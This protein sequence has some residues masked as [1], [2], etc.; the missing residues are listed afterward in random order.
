MT[1]PKSLIELENQF[2]VRPDELSIQRPGLWPSEA[3]V[4]YE[5]DGTPICRGKCMRAVFYRAMGVPEDDGK[6]GQST[7]LMMKAHLGRAAEGQTTNRWKEM[8]IWA[9]NSIKFYNRQYV[10]SGELDTILNLDGKKILVEQKSFYGFNASREICGAKRPPIPGCPKWGHFLQSCVYADEYQDKVD[11]CRLYYLE[12]GD[13]HRVEFLVGVDRATGRPYWQQIPGPYWNMYSD[14]R[15]LAPFTMDDIYARF[16]QLIKYIRLEQVPPRDF[17]H[18]WDKATIQWMYDHDE[19]S[20]SKYKDYMSGKK[21]AGNWECA[22]CSRASKCLAD[23][24]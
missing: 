13:G 9:G 14:K 20:Q 11:E 4:M 6:G 8:G 1:Q 7:N 23:G 24:E 17:K 18:T 3:S 15:V 16:K 12:R 2:V 21:Q 22:Y 19:I 5:I 10:V